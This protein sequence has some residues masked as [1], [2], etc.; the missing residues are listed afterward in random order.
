LRSFRKVTR[1]GYR[2]KLYIRRTKDRKMEEAMASIRHALSADGS[3][4]FLISDL[5]QKVTRG[6]I[7]LNPSFQRRYVHS[8]KAATELIQSI[9]LGVRINPVVFQ[10]EKNGKYSVTDGQQRITSLI[11]YMRGYFP[12]SLK[13]EFCIVDV[14]IDYCKDIMLGGHDQNEFVQG[15]LFGEFAEPYLREQVVTERLL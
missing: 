6:D 3:K 13:E 14:I 8:H 15:L 11:Q 12:T 7:L 4:S 5:E 1:C 2:K 9:F 10:R